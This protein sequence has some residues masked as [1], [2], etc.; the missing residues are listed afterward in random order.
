MV[1]GGVKAHGWACWGRQE[2]CFQ[3]SVLRGS[4]SYSSKRGRPMASMETAE[5]VFRDTLGE[6]L[7]S[8]KVVIGIAFASQIATFLL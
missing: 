2:I 1:L 4:E 5:P 6:P 7:G 8:D 3:V